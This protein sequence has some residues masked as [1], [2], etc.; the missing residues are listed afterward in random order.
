MEELET[1]L[2]NSKLR[3]FICSFASLVQRNSRILSRFKILSCRLPLFDICLIDFANLSYQYRGNYTYGEEFL[4]RELLRIGIVEYTDEVFNL[5]SE[6]L[7]KVLN[8]VFEDKY[9]TATVEVSRDD[10]YDSL[11]LRVA[12]IGDVNNS[13]I[14]KFMIKN[15]ENY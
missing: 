11:T 6:N 7:I 8:K 2:M 1:S 14:I 13:N 10:S 9:G 15:S 12:V 4:D 5:N 3:F